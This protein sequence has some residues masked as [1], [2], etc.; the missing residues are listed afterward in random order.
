MIALPTILIVED[1]FVIGMEACLLAE[2]LGLRVLGPV[3]TV[4]Q[5]L[6]AVE[7]EAPAAAVLDVDLGEDYVWPVAQA[8]ASL[9]V[10]FLLATARCKQDFPSEFVD[11]PYLPKPWISGDFTAAL[12]RLVPISP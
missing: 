7:G 12:H 8:L 11:R 1:N 5:A 3:A 4:Q 10:P 2:R 9:S 6:A